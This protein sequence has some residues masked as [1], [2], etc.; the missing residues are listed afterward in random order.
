M[1]Q[2][3][4]GV[5]FELVAEIADVPQTE[6]ERQ[7]RLRS[8]RTRP[9][10]GVEV[11]EE[12]AADL[13]RC[14]VRMF[15]S[16]SHFRDPVG[17]ILG[18]GARAV[19]HDGVATV[20]LLGRRPVEPIAVRA[21]GE[22]SFID[23]VRVHHVVHPNRSDPVFLVPIPRRFTP[24]RFTRRRLTGRALRR[25]RRPTRPDRDPA[26]RS[27]PCG[28]REVGQ[29][30]P[31]VLAADRLRMELHPPHRQHPVAHRHQDAVVGPRL[32]LQLVGDIHHR[33]RVIPDRPE[34]GGQ[35]REQAA[36]VVVDGAESSVPRFGGPYHRAA[37]HMA[38][39][40]VAQAHPEHG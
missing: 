33:Q 34:R 21:T 16:H 19:S 12:G 32:L 31:A 27:H 17:H 9:Q 11:V 40:L 30:L 3:A 35:S 18:V 28:R 20:G 1:R 23:A 29:Q 36:A 39:A 4:A 10:L 15:D 14:T 38:Q 7:L 8:H 6:R 22:Q 2:L 26:V 24:R 13:L 37:E 5:R 25:R